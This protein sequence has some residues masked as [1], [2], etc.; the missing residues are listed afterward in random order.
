MHSLVPPRPSGQRRPCPRPRPGARGHSLRVS[1]YHWRE[2]PGFGSGGNTNP[3]GNGKPFGNSNPF[4]GLGGGGAAQKTTTTKT[5]AAPTTPAAP[6][7]TPTPPP[8]THTTAES[9]APVTPSSPTAKKS[10]SSSAIHA[11]AGNLGGSEDSEE[12]VGPVGS[13]HPVMTRA[14][15]ARVAHDMA[16]SPS[17]ARH[18]SL[19]HGA[20]ETTP[21]LSHRTTSSTPTPTR[22]PPHLTPTHIPLLPPPAVNASK[23]ASHRHGHSH[24]GSMNMRALVLHVLGDALGNVGV[25]ATRLILLLAPP[26]WIVERPGGICRPGD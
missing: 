16:R 7:A 8:P 1:R 6:P 22:L 2:Q 15:I 24:A 20:S 26:S 12:Y 10:S 18:D 17:K 19:G 11:P 4:G 9:K 5:K 14:S 3:F 21:L 23:D 25:I 13:G